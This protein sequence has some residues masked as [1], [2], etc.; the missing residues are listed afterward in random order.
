MQWGFKI[1]KNIKV[2]PITR[3][4]IVFHVVNTNILSSEIQFYFT[5]ANS[6]VNFGFRDLLRMILLFVLIVLGK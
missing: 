6:K 2:P 5:I 1:L 4:A 3:E